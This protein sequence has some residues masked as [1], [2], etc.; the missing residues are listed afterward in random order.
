MSKTISQR[1][2]ACLFIGKE[3]NFRKNLFL[4]YLGN[5]IKV[6]DY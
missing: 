1:P 2:M 6:S 3:I 5:E 4:Y